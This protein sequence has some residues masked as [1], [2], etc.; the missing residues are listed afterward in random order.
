MF[1][2]AVIKVPGIVRKDDLP[3]PCVKIA[4]QIIEDIHF[5][6]LNVTL[7]SPRRGFKYFQVLYTTHK[8]P[9]DLETKKG[10]V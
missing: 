10:V 3:P 2:T 1:I 6:K 8:F 7:Y 5:D 4:L 9:S